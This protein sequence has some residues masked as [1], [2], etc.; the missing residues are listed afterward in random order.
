[1]AATSNA[2]NKRREA[3]P[4]FVFMLAWQPVRRCLPPSQSSDTHT[5]LQGE[6]FQQ[7]NNG[8]N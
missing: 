8:S 2:F 6:V 7:L 1:M 5:P 4:Y 3:E